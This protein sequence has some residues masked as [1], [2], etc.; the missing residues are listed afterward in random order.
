MLLENDGRNKAALQWAG[1]KGYL[2][3]F[4]QELLESALEPGY[5]PANEDKALAMHI[6]YLLL[7]PTDL[8]AQSKDQAE[9]K[10]FVLRPF[11]FA[12]HKY[13]GFYAPWTLKALPLR[14]L[15]DSKHAM[16]EVEKARGATAP[17]MAA[18]R[19]AE[20]ASSS[21][22]GQRPG[23]TSGAPPESVASMLADGDAQEPPNP[24]MADL[25][26]R[27]RS[28]TITHCGQTLILRPPILA[29]AAYFMF[30]ML[31]ESAPDVVELTAITG[32]GAEPGTVNRRPNNDG[33][34]RPPTQLGLLHPSLSGGRVGE[35]IIE[36]SEVRGKSILGLQSED[37][38]QDLTRLMACHNPYASIGLR[39]CF[40]KTTFTGTW[41]GRFCFFD[42]NSYREMLAGR[43]QS[44]Y[45]GPFGE[46]PQVWKL[47]EHFVRVGEG[48][49]Q[50][51]GNHSVIG[52]GYGPD[53]SV[54]ELLQ[55][56]RTLEEARE[57]SRQLYNGKRRADSEGK[58]TSG[59]SSSGHRTDRPSDY[60]AY[61]QFDEDDGGISA[62]FGHIDGDASGERY[63]MLI[64]GIGH[65]AWGR[66]ALRGRVRAWDGMLILCKEYKPEGRGRW[67]YRGYS[68][69]GQ[70]LVGRWRDSFTP[71]DLSGYE[72]P[73]SFQKRLVES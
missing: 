7:D 43:M 58:Q 65:S 28:T 68:V 10:L 48:H 35:V 25:A 54:E 19:E 69:A 14:R 60:E 9:E 66:F 34:M 51:G 11:V 29:H 5:P 21:V 37:H 45:E 64:S 56:P 57:N 59:R 38:D 55:Q 39:P 67:L 17:L 1:I 24:F 6:D 26:P 13:E 3:L 2:A 42:F 36:N 44:L 32:R 4:H 52:A 12:S 49:R 73:F 72:G 20:A 22:L 30:F 18:A 70:K 71:G 46:Q 40:F 31:V 63:E 23:S 16:E 53:E 62:G 47:K 61:P 15:E 33:E 8:A 27:V 41:E 50:E